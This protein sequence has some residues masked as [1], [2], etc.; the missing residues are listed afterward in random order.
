VNWYTVAKVFDGQQAGAHRLPFKNKQSWSLQK[1]FALDLFSEAIIIIFVCQA[2][3]SS[4]DEA[5]SSRH[6][7][8]NTHVAVTNFSLVAS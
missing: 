1:I 7:H 8:R 2:Q 4:V 3:F 5:S 6:T